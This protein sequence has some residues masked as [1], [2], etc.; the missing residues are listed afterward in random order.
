MESPILQEFYRNI[1]IAIAHGSLNDALNTMEEALPLIQSW[2]ETQQVQ[3]IRDNYKR[4]ISYL[5]QGSSDPSRRQ[6]FHELF[7]KLIV[8]AEST[9]RRL[10][11]PQYPVE[12]FLA[13]DLTPTRRFHL[14]WTCGQWSP[15][16]MDDV[17]VWI[18]DDRHSIEE[19]ALCVSAITLSLCNYFDPQKLQLLC[20]LCHAQEE[21]ISARALVGIVLTVVA[22]EIY[23]HYF[24]GL[25]LEVE[26]IV[27]DELLAQK[28]MHIQDVLFAL[29]MTPIAGKQLLND[30][31]DFH[32]ENAD[33][34][35][36]LQEHMLQRMKK[37]QSLQERG[38][39]L[40]LVTFKLMSRTQSFFNESANWFWPFTVH[41]P[42]LPFHELPKPMEMLFSLGM[43]SA[44]DK[45]AFLLMAGKHEVQIQGADGEELTPDALKE[46]V[47]TTYDTLRFYLF[48]TFR[49]YML[50]QDRDIHRNPFNSD[51]CLV[52][53]DVFKPLFHTDD[54]ML[55]I[56][57]CLSMLEQY[58][59]ALD[60]FRVLSI[61]HP[62]SSSILIHMGHC[63]AALNNAAASIDCFGAALTYRPDDIDLQTNYA[64]ALLMDDR[65]KEAEKWLY[66]LRYEGHETPEVRRDIAWC[67]LSEG[68]YQE[69]IDIYRQLT[70]SK[71]VN[72]NDYVN[73][74]HAMLLTDDVATAI[75]CYEQ[76]LQM[77][78]VD[79]PDDAFY[80]LFSE[81]EDWFAQRGFDHEQ[82]AL[83]ADASWPNA[84]SE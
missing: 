29:R 14:I 13:D 66:K 52:N 74:G 82:L 12:N 50:S 38:C 49:F 77:D 58:D 53:Y 34:P 32:I 7:Q 20:H 19:R 84:A 2:E 44:T 28:I 24:D 62:E 76:S 18:T 26:S 56:A 27:N 25:L 60:I 11:L 33:G 71:D 75:T 39:D 30:L 40:N 47:D 9:A 21:E 43:H 4:L 70:T 22:K 8:V 55:S 68:E 35:E 67:L 42:E 16:M 59:E 69:A 17:L 10:E 15:A 57:I 46:L 61:K 83:I 23:L 54:Q 45:Y 73:M 41:H 3:S 6:I 1:K 79:T 5:R 81:D 72:S 37:L 36:E 51:L 31:K 80:Y 64:H 78:E 48:D 63:Y 65:I